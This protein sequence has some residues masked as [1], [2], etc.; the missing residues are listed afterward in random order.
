MVSKVLLLASALLLSAT[1]P[2]PK[3]VQSFNRGEAALAK[4]RLDEAAAAYR[5]AITESPGYAAAL[6]GLGSVLFRQSRRD[7]AV[8]QFR[9]AIQADPDF[10]LAYFNLGYVSRKG[11]DFAS[12]AQAYERYTQLDPN[13]PDGF[14]GLAESY[15][16]LGET[17]RAIAAYEQYLAKEKR[18]TEQKW[19]DR[20]KENLAQL[21]AQAQA[22]PAPQPAAPQAAAPQGSG[23]PQAPESMASTGALTPG[24]QSTG[25]PPG[26]APSPQ[27]SAQRISDG[28][29]FMQ[30]RRYREASLAYQDASNAD[31]SS[32]EALF[33][34]GNSYAVL[35]YYAQ[36]IDRWNRVA[37]ITSDPAVRK[38]AQDNIAK[39]QAKMA[40]VGG[41]SPQAQ[42]R[43]P[44]SGPIADS[45]RER[46]RQA[47]E[48]GVRLINQKDY[49]GA[50]Q[51]L[52]QAIQL[53]PTLAV[54]YVARGS[55]NVGQRRFAEAAADYQYAL[56]L[57]G[58]LASPLYG[59]GE[60]YRGMGRTL[61]A[62]QYY[63]R[64]ASANTPDVRPE[65]QTEARRKA[66]KLR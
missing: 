15:R 20:A 6:N 60:A 7:E 11:N 40:Q 41:G 47:Y 44:G 24:A 34:L 29:R 23:Q 57:D 12:A 1:A 38:S 48:E 8:A 45:T 19:V 2:S 27:L 17:Q 16:Q 61:D 22:A 18:P 58:R 65:L 53:E 21:R 3:A 56:K 64:Y 4:D 31:P 54:A 9:A 33:K 51:S 49:A 36:A 28:D 55:A 52:T 62:R 13:D 30:E 5:E 42:G 50:V 39:A 43:T 63:E 32:I 59:L 35:G 10:K 14:Y 37:Q 26:G 25:I 46:A 66:E